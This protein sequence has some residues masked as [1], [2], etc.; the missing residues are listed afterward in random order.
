MNFEKTVAF[1]EWI[2][3]EY[4]VVSVFITTTCS[5]VGKSPHMR[6]TAVPTDFILRWIC[7]VCCVCSFETIEYKS[8]HSFS[9]LGSGLLSIRIPNSIT[10]IFRFVSS[11]ELKLGIRALGYFSWSR[12]S[13]INFPL[14]TAVRLH[15]LILYK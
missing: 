11:G 14:Y 7:S 13:V 8:V 2:N 15:F 10:F 9:S 4:C 3:F 1:V 6:T 12:N 5:F